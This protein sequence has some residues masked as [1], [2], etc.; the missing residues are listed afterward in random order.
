MSQFAPPRNT[1]NNGRMDAH[2]FVPRRP[3]EFLH[4]CAW[5]REGG[6]CCSDPSASPYTATARVMLLLPP[7]CCHD[8]S[9]L[10]AN[11]RYSSPSFSPSTFRAA[12]TH[13]EKTIN[14]LLLS[15]SLS[16][17]LPSS[18]LVW[19][20]LACVPRFSKHLLK[21]II[22][23]QVEVL[24]LDLSMVENFFWQSFALSDFIDFC[25]RRIHGQGFL[26]HK[27]LPRSCL[28][29]SLTL[30]PPPLLTYLQR[31]LFSV[32]SFSLPPPHC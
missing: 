9:H 14:P 24:A 15:P 17:S 32:P 5:K 3:M 10:A 22:A 19:C 6:Q 2:S 23:A 21:V 27:F 8:R 25:S 12:K 11:T 4:R 18:I 28:N 20:V 30:S 7:P 13:A 1:P 26:L 29:V 31:R 16:V